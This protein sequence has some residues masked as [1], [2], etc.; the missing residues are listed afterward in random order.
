MPLRMPRWRA[1]PSPPRLGRRHLLAGSALVG[2]ALLLVWSAATTSYILFHDDALRALAHRS[3]GQAAGYE[4]EI[5]RLET[6]LMQER[7]QKLVEQSRLQTTV[8]QMRQ[9]QM[10]LEARHGL[11]S[12]MLDGTG[13]TAAPPR[14]GERTP[15]ASPISDTILLAPADTREALGPAAAS[16]RIAADKAPR[17][18]DSE[19]AALTARIDTLERRQVSALNAVEERMEAQARRMR[20]VFASLGIPAP[21][22]PSPKVAQASATGGP[23]VPLGPDT[24]VFDRQS[25]RAKMVAADLKWLRKRLDGV[26]LRRPVPGSVETTSGFGARID[27]FLHQAAFHTGI[28]F[29]GAMGDPVRATAAGRVVNADRDGGYG[30]MV[31]L[32]HGNGLTTRYAH[33]S[34]ISVKVGDVLPAGGIVGRVGSTGRSTGAHLH[35]ETRINGEAVDPQ[36]FLRAGLRLDGAV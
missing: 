35:Y 18:A 27:P 13:G 34:V 12:E 33:L 19:I 15:K 2:G 9:R 16:E 20:G 7:S 23:F 17:D 8:E 25:G 10:M 6:E 14:D 11:L 24:D 21:L 29:R 28:D 4:R 32:D 26:P 22:R 31:E 1:T 36:R 30:L 5:E 3:S